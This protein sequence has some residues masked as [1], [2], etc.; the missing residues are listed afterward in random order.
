[1]KTLRLLSAGLVAAGLALPID[2]AHAIPRTFVSGTGSDANPCTAASPCLTFQAAHIATDAGGEITCLDAGDFGGVTITKSI[3]IDC[4]GTL[5]GASSGITVNA[6]LAT[7][8]LRNLTLNG[9][10]TGTIGV[11][12]TAANA[13]FIE[14]CTILG[15]NG[16]AAG[17]GIGVKFA[18]AGTISEL[19]VTDSWIGGNGRA[20]DGGGIIIQPT[21]IGQARVNIE[22]SQILDNTFGI[23]ANGTGT[24]A[25]SS[26]QIR[27]TAVAGSVVHGISSFTSG[28]T[29]SITT[30]R[31]SSLLNG[32]AG[33]LA[34]GSGAF[35]LL[36]NSTVMSN[37][38]GLS[39]VGGGGIFSYQ[40]NHL[41]GNVSDG[42]PT[43]V[44]TTK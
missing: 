22:N 17:Q 30:D 39:A 10:G 24:S 7:V 15:F 1:M 18:P 43:A 35:V 4:A 2:P 37:G 34:Q 21:G 12:F 41:T 9:L 6:N 20:A 27:D 23:F 5:G 13:L 38:T 28:T 42:A 44:L 29:T 19:Y 32:Q 31:T 25:A 33:I 3:T 11:S 14:S 8:R 26:V 16:G 36:A 40:N